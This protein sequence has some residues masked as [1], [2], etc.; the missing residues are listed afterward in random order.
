MNFSIAVALKRDESLTG[1]V[2]LCLPMATEKGLTIQYGVYW[3]A[4]KSRQGGLMF[5][6]AGELVWGEPLVAIGTDEEEYEEE[7]EEEPAVEE[8]TGE[9]VGATAN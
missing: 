7:G 2:A 8:T 6:E 9:V 4:H 3:D 1:L 5:H